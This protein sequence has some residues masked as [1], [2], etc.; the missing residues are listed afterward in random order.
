MKQ[1]RVLLVEDDVDFGKS[2]SMILR[3]KG[4]SVFLAVSAIEAMKK[5]KEEPFQIII[6][7]VLMPELS[8]LEFLK[9]L[10]EKNSEPAP[11]IMLTGYGSVKEAVEAMKIGAYDY[12]LKPVNQDEICLT[13]EKALEFT[14][15]KQENRRLRQELS[16]IKGNMLY[17][18]NPAMRNLLE[19]AHLLS[20]SDVSVLI[21][22]ESGTG[23]EVLA[24]YIHD[25]SKRADKPFMAI[26]CQAYAE[27]L[28]ES[29]LFGY[30]GGSF[31]GA[32][33]KG[34]QGK[35]EM[36]AC[37]TLFLDE[38]GELDLATQVKLLRVLD[39][40][41]IEPVGGLKPIPVNFRLISATNQDL[42]ERIKRQSFR[43]DLYYRINTVQLKIP[44][45]RERWEDILPLARYFLSLYAQQQK[46]N[47]TRF[48]P[49][50][51]KLLLGYIWPGNIRELRNVIE[52]AV[53]LTQSSKLDASVL[54]VNDQQ[55]AAH[56]YQGFSYAEARKG[57]ERGYLQ[58][59]Y[60]QCEGNISA[61]SRIIELDRKH[62][63][64][65]LAEYRIFRKS[66]TDAEQAD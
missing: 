62:L 30:K 27:T 3:Q 16:E 17:S 11:V 29:E 10:K 14:H 41:E 23:K 52:G 39:N 5:L 6:S 55:G 22:G 58:Y 56:M 12:F 61:M 13:I 15:L 53:A 28:L 9:L 25:E 42:S 66:R 19:E 1:A 64:N 20:Q 4:Y 38:V 63:Y 51:E 26:N 57:F 54:R 46:K 24:R 34:K 47:V 31:T 21:T 40:K 50:A 65:K 18:D 59:Y 43:E 37:G 48:T 2:F 36:A 32:N 45:L 8:G 33:V 7:D 49:E 35:I 44:S 60:K